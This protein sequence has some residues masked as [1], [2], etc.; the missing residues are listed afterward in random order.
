MYKAVFRNSKIALLFAAMTLFSAITMV[1]TSEDGGT[2]VDLKNMAGNMRTRAEAEAAAA[3]ARAAGPA[4][5]QTAAPV[6]GDYAPEPAPAASAAGAPP[7]A[8]SGAPEG[9][10]GAPSVPVG[11]NPNPPA[12]GS[13]APAPGGYA[14]VSEVAAA[15]Q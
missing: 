2:L 1:G 9:I 7:A 12:P 10:T 3:A 11:I 4:S 15:P 14:P 6:F 13:A 5:I 8:G